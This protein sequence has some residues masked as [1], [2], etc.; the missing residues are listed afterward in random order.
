MCYLCFEEA[1]DA[2]VGEDSFWGAT[3]PILGADEH[4]VRDCVQQVCQLL[5][6]LL[7]D[8]HLKEEISLGPVIQIQVDFRNRVDD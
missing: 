5:L 4:V 1:V 6:G 8:L 3:L 7:V 2:R